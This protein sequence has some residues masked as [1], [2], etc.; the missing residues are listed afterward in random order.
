MRGIPT[1]LWLKSNGGFHPNLTRLIMVLTVLRFW[2]LRVPPPSGCRQFLTYDRSPCNRQ[3]SAHEA[4]ESG[5]L[6]VAFRRLVQNGWN[7][8]LRSLGGG[9]ETCGQKTWFANKHFH[10]LL[11]CEMQRFLPE[12]L[13]VCTSGHC[14]TE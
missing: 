8:C 6:E 12:E 10:N 11:I 13:S 1:T 5:E 14:G 9:G 2:L 3:V 4:P 7:P